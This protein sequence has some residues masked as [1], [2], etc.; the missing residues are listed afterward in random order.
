[1]HM[2]QLNRK[3]HSIA[4]FQMTRDAVNVRKQFTLYQHNYE[5]LEDIVWEAMEW[6]MKSLEVEGNG[7]AH[8][9]P[10][11]SLHQTQNQAKPM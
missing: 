5:I 9:N 7:G 10:Y 4:V 1:M 2:E 8:S 3:Q 11:I 6:R